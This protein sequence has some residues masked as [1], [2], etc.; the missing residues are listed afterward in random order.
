M[1]AAES[2]ADIRR[3]IDRAATKAGRQAAQI[4]L[5]AVSKTRSIEE[6]RPLLVAGQRVF[7]ENRVQEA[8][9][10]WPALRH[11]ATVELHLVGRLQSNKAAAAVRHFDF[12]HTLDRLSLIEPLV[13]AMATYGRRV[14]CFLQVNIGNEPQKGGC[15]IEALPGLL[16]MS[17]SR[18]IPLAGLMCIPPVD[19]ESA[20]YFALLAK[21]ATRHGLMGLSMGMSADFETAIELGAT[22]VRVGEALFGPRGDSKTET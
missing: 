6:I 16:E 22:H 4:S 17:R 18:G 9:V 21:L 14:P 13:V 5:I 7:A 8:V 20:P 12:I 10:K 19:R 3:R 2:L 1:N 15:A 11:E